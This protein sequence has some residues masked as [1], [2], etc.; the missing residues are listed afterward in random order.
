MHLFKCTINKSSDKGEKM[1]VCVPTIGYG[2]LDDY[3][4][5]HFGRA[6]TFTVV[7]LETN[8][9]E[10]LP[11]TGEHMGGSGH[12]PQIMVNV[13]LDVILCSGLG[14]RAARMFE[15]LD[16]EVYVGARGTVRE[17]IREWKA[18]ML[19]TVTDENVCRMHKHRG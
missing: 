6:P 13:V 12:P 5:V 11:N 17:A 14:W 10:V 15:Q 1:K 3:V 7:D 16:I 19:Q 8:E 4:S 9:V 2:G 18:G